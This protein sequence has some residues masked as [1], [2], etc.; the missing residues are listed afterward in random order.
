MVDAAHD[1]ESRARDTINQL[2]LEIA[3]LTKL[4]EQ[5]A[6]LNFGQDAS[7]QELMKQKE[8]L[9]RERDTQLDDIVK[10]RVTQYQEQGTLSLTMHIHVHWTLCLQLRKQ[11]AETTEQQ[12]KA[13]HE[14][15]IAE[16]KV[17]EVYITIHEDF[18]LQEL[19]ITP[20]H[21]C[22]RRFRQ[23]TRRLTVKPGERLSWKKT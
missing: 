5:G 20:N 6:G 3:N 2:K 9:T 11:V 10:V 12:R 7:V 18:L 17:L 15:E 23:R 8:E 1:K 22:A 21:R 13:E 4:V 19:I 16:Q 14:R